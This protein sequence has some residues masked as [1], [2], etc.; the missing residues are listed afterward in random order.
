MFK[1]K[2]NSIDWD[3]E[4]RKLDKLNSYTSENGVFEFSDGEDGSLIIKLHIS[5]ELQ[6]AVIARTVME[7]IDVDRIT[8]MERFSFDFI[9]A[10]GLLFSV[11]DTCREASKQ[12]LHDN[13]IYV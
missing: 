8:D 10:G 5:D 12:T 2:G 6:K 9:N 1:K 7:Y 4:F 11:F 13:G 3:A